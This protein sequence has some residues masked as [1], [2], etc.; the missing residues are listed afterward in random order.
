MTINSSQVASGFERVHIIPTITQGAQIPDQ[1][2]GSEIR[3]GS[4]IGENQFHA[5]LT[6][7]LN[8]G[9][10]SNR[11]VAAHVRGDFRT[12]VI[13]HHVSIG[14]DSLHSVI[15]ETG[16]D[17]SAWFPQTIGKRPGN[18]SFSV[19]SVSSLASGTIVDCHFSGCIAS[20]RNDGYRGTGIKREHVGGVVHRHTSVEF[21]FVGS[22]QFVLHG[23]HI[24]GFVIGLVLVFGY[25]LVRGKCGIGFIVFFAGTG[26]EG[27]AK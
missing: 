16:S 6:F 10:S 7:Q 20:F 9:I 23:T 13:H 2:F 27:K 4:V 12:G 11:F 5:Y 15:Q 21:G 22:H 18:D 26:C 8:R 17:H 1:I 14:I 25:L 3:E 19:P 24:F